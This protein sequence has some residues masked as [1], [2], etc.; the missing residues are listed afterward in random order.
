MS[1]SVNFP[2]GREIFSEAERNSLKKP[3]ILEIPAE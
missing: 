2:A 3:V 1:V